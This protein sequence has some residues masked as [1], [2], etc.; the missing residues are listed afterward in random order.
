MGETNQIRW[1]NHFD[2]HNVPIHV[3]NEIEIAAPAEIVWAWLIRAQQWPNWYKNASNVRF[4]EGSPPDLALGTRFT[5]KTFGIGIDSRVQEFVPFERIAWNGN[6]IGI[7]VYHAWL[8]LRTLSGCKVITEESQHGVIARL[9]AKLFPNRMW[10]Y[11]QIWLE[12]L[13]RNALQGLP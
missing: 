10:K 4:L 3:R 11:H 13:N 2:P 9:S 5:W 7:H 6:A 8:I 12:N 1:P